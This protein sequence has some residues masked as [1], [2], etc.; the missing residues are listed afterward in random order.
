MTKKTGGLQDA[1]DLIDKVIGTKVDFVSLS[2][3]MSEA[4]LSFKR[5][6]D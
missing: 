5:L 6:T 2:Q 3:N 1:I 4:H